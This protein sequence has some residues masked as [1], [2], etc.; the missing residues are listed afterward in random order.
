MEIE[1]EERN[2]RG[3][4]RLPHSLDTLVPSHKECRKKGLA[5]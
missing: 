5:R 4:S 1:I 2:E 3:V